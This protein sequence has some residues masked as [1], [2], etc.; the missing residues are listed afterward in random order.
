MAK[1]ADPQSGTQ[2]L[3]RAPIFVVASAKPIHR[4]LTHVLHPWITTYPLSL[5]PF[6]SYPSKA[7]IAPFSPP[8]AALA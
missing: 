5:P 8:S 3:I 2:A 1:L 7:E 6:R 4:S